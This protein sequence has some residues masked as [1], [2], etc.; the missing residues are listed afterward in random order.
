MPRAAPA[1]VCGLLLAGGKSRRMGGRDK[2][3]LTLGGKP[4]LQ[5][6]LETVAPQVG[7]L[8]I[9]ANGDPAAYAAFGLPVAGDSVPGFAGPLSGV[10][11]GMEWARANVPGCRWVA[12]ATCDAPFLPGDLVARLRAAVERER[13]DMA[14][15][16][17]AGRDHPVFG[18]WPVRLAGELR[19]AVAEEGVRK[20]DVWTGRHRLAHADFDAAP[21]DPFF[22]VNRPEDLDVARAAAG[23][24][25]P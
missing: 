15:V 12:S 23:A 7:A 14:C 1:P 3:F 18:L 22:N 4:L 8:V 19:R 10:L 5:R 25:G 13:A 6:V 20:V 11:T 9:N 24:P 21:I 16:R 17:S 2:A